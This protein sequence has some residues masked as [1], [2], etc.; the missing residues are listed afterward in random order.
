MAGKKV[1]RRYSTDRVQVRGLT[2]ETK[3]CWTS[4]A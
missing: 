1:R 3:P 2:F 4:E